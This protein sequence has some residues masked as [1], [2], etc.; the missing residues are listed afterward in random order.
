MN[1]N[2]LKLVLN[3]VTRKT[4]GIVDA[5]NN[6]NSNKQLDNGKPDKRKEYRVR[7]WNLHKRKAHAKIPNSWIVA[8]SDKWQWFENV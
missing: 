1:I 5:G 2:F 8:S 3:L 6:D 7:I 4:L